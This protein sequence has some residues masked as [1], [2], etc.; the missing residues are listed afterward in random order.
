MKMMLIIIAA[1]TI[2]KGILY[3]SS[4]RFVYM[5]INASI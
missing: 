2:P 3:S 1:H 4:L 5:N